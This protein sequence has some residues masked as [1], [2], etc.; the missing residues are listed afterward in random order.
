M[1]RDLLLENVAALCNC[2]NQWYNLALDSSCQS[3]V[4]HLLTYGLN[5]PLADPST[6]L[7]INLSIFN[8][9]LSYISETARFIKML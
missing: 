7:N 1:P 5:L 4:T 8:M 6:I 9:F 3:S 2:V